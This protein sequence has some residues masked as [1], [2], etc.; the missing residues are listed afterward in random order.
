MR[1]FRSDW[2]TIV[3]S[4]FFSNCFAAI[5]ILDAVSPKDVVVTPGLAPFRIEYNLPQNIDCQK[6]KWAIAL[7]FVD[8][9]NQP[10]NTL[11]DAPDAEAE[12][13]GNK[14]V[15][16]GS[17]DGIVLAGKP[18]K[19]KIIVVDAPDSVPSDLTVS[20]PNYV[21]HFSLANGCSQEGL[22]QD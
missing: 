10:F 16:T 4:D 8:D 17:L 14:C 2:F 11:S 1:K 20:F 6:D 19:L 9:Q 22:C 13:E 5:L 15:I 3:A 7:S 18:D 12:R 21:A